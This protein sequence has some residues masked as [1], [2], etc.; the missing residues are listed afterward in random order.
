MHKK[1]GYIKG[2][3]NT[4]IHKKDTCISKCFQLRSFKNAF[5]KHY[6]YTNCYLYAQANKCHFSLS[7]TDF[8]LK[9]D[10]SEIMNDT[11]LSAFLL[12]IIK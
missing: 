5:F 8:I 2:Y 1:Q 12:S 4:R 10:L 7:P 6:F 3:K 11:K 9:E